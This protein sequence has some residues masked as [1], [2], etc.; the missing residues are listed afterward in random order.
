[1]LTALLTLTVPGTS[2]PPRVDTG[3]L[4]SVLT[5]SAIHQRHVTNTTAT[6]THRRLAPYEMMIEILGFGL[7][8][9]LLWR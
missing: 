6:H 3:W 5:E 2:R 9:S 4:H 7:G 1:M 8:L